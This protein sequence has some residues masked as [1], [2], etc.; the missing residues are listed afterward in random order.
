M[1]TQTLVELVQERPDIAWE[2]APLLPERGEWR[3]EDYLWLTNH[4]N[5]LVEFSDGY[6]EVLPM[7]TDE[8]QRIVLFFYRMLYSFII[9]YTSGIV[10]VAP[11]RVRLQNGKYREPDVIVL[12]SQTDQ[13]RENQY[14]NG[15]DLV[16][17]IVSP[18]D[19]DRDLVTKREEYAQIGIPEY[20]IIHPQ[21]EMI[22]VLR[23]QGQ[24]YVEHGEFERG[25]T[26]ASVVLQGFV[27]DVDAALDAR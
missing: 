24:S 22:T 20:W 4:T 7:P 15:A 18:D 19:P 17:E 9:T 14:W 10:L 12:L 23:L 13:R 26:A 1:S 5:R 8:H 21:K 25:Q 2:V 3:E 6:I 11:L 27:V 16:M